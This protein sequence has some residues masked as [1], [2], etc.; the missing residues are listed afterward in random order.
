M[1]KKNPLQRL[2]V[3]SFLVILYVFIYIF[4]HSFAKPETTVSWYGPGFDG[5]ITANGETYNQNALTAASPTLPFNTR[6]RITNTHNDK[7]VIVRI[8]DRGP[9]AML[10][11]G[12]PV[13]PL[14]PHIRRSFDLSKA[15][16]KSIGNLKK[17]I[18]RVEYKIL[19]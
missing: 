10:P 8:N 9:F 15:S 5:R 11:N 14:K 7:S 19:K 17:G 18:L 6:V 12:K 13:R 2:T 4:L 3:V 1:K 16:F